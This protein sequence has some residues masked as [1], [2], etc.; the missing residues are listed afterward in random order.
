MFDTDSHGKTNESG[1]ESSERTK[2]PK[3]QGRMSSIKKVRSG[4]TRVNTG[5]SMEQE[6]NRQTDSKEKEKARMEG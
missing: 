5:S 3:R 6:T 2:E 1:N 4:S